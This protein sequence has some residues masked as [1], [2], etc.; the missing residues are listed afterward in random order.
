MPFK[1]QGSG[2][3]VQGSKEMQI[4]SLIQGDIPLIKCPFKHIGELTGSGEQDVLGIIEDMMKKGVIRKFGAIL[5]H[6]KAG[7]KRNAMLLWAVPPS[8][9]EAVGNI[10]ASFP[11]IT[12]CYQRTPA[13]A[14]KYNI[15][16]M[17]HLRDNGHGLRDNEYE[18]LI[19]RLSSATGIKD[20]LLLISE[21]EFKKNSMEYF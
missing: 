9:S 19:Q 18:L 4:A 8:K 2:F 17:I 7:F 11:E 3:R 5:R 20:Y 13:F 1:V 21:E 12:H 16:T 6:Q 14:G 10:L 15:F